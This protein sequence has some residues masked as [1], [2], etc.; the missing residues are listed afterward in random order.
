MRRAQGFLTAALLLVAT[1][2]IAQQIADPAFDVTVKAPAYPREHPRVVIDEAHH[3]FH[4]ADGRYKPLATLLRNDGYDVRPG[5]AAF[6]DASLSGARVIVISNALGPGATAA[7]DTS[8]PAFT[9]AECD[10]VLAWVRGGGSLLLISDHTP[11]GMANAILGRAFGVTMGQGFV[12]TIAETH[13]LPN[14][15]SEIIFSRENGL[16]G[17][18][19]ITRGRT[20]DER[21]N[22]VFSFTGQSLTVPP[23]AVAI[24]SLGSDAWEAPTRADLQAVARDAAAA[25]N[26]AA[27]TTAHA[28]H[29]AGRAQGLAMTTGAGRVVVLGEAAL[30]SAQITGAAGQGRMGMNVPGSDD[31]QFALNVLHWLSRLF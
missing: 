17:D 21:V 19:P 3:N 7:T 29:V 6:T 25:P 16:L 9:E 24:L 11:M 13:H 10:A 15:P 30:M 23:G 8:P 27:F 22:T 4:T 28:L 14:R 12:R 26:P 31:R 20:D 18:H 5:T 1:S 2:L